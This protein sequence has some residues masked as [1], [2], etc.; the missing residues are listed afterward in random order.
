MTSRNRSRRGFNNRLPAGVGS[1]FRSELLSALDGETFKDQY[2]RDELFSKYLDPK[3]VS[4]SQRQAK[5]IQKWLGCEQTNMQTN[6][7]LIFNDVDFGWT[8]S[9][10]FLDEVRRLICSILGM[11]EIR[12]YSLFELN[13]IGILDIVPFSNGASTRIKRSETAAISKLAG[14]AHITTAAF[15]YWDF[16]TEGS[17]LTGLDLQFVN[18]SVMFTV[19]K[20]SDID[21]VACKEPEVNMSLQ[22][23]VGEF[24]RAKLRKV[25]IDLRDQTNN[26]RLARD[27]YALGLATVDLSAA[28]DSISSMLAFH[29]LPFSLWTICEHLRVKSTLVPGSDVPHSLEMFSSMGNGFTFELESLLFYAITRVVARRSGVKGRISVYGDDI[30]CHRSIVPRLTRLFAWLGFRVNSKK[31]HSRG[32]FRESCGKHY[33]AGHDVTPFYIRREVL[34]VSDLILHLNHILSWDARSNSGENLTFFT[35]EKLAA[36]HRRWSTFVPSF[37]WGG[38]DYD[39]NTSLVTGHSSRKKIVPVK[40]GVSFDSEPAMV[41]WFMMAEHSTSLYGGVDPMVIQSGTERSRTSPSWFTPPSIGS[42]EIDPKREVGKTVR[43]NRPP[44]WVK[45]YTSDPYMLF[46]ELQYGSHA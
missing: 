10:S 40:K 23:G 38:W 44:S 25:G 2:L 8:T 34:T 33:N 19:D 3:I 18:S 20:K 26:Q 7:R 39:S 45:Q 22:R 1:K 9:E 32:S 17:A 41:H 35:T 11:D 28:S 31:T 4:P 30:I 27:A 6:E 36:F 16:L 21:R 37:L 13:S 12:H 14:V 42:L 43:Y 5:A 24:I 46:K 15:P 29:C